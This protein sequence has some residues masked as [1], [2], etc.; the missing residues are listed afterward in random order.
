MIAVK[1]AAKTIISIRITQMLIFR[2]PYKCYQNRVQIH[3]ASAET[4]GKITN[5][6]STLSQNIPIPPDESLYLFRIFLRM[7]CHIA[8]LESRADHKFCLRHIN[9]DRLL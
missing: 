4:A 8:A 3:A 7:S 9:G 1:I 6:F 5:S 2:P